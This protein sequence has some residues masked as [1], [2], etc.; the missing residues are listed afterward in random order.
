MTVTRLYDHSTLD[1]KTTR[2]MTMH[3]LV[4]TNKGNNYVKKTFVRME[5]IYACHI[6]VPNNLLKKVF[7]AK[8]AH[9]SYGTSAIRL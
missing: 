2:R 5:N 1:S 7:C 6:V 3:V 9:F 8:Y 4:R